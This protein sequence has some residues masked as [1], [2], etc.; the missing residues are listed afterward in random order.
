MAVALFKKWS[1]K[2]LDELL[3]LMRM[4][5]DGM[6]RQAASPGIDTP[7]GMN[8]ETREASGSSLLSR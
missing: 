5:A 4:L 2:D 7:Y 6:T 3:R 8:R 1:R